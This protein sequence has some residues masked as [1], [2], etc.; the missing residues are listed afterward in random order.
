MGYPRDGILQFYISGMEKGSAYGMDLETDRRTEASL[1]EQRYFRVRYYP[2]PLAPLASLAPV[3]IRDTR[4][5]T[6]HETTRPRRM[7]FTL[8]REEISALDSSF[9]RLVGVEPYGFVESASLR[10][11]RSVESLSQ[12]LNSGAGHKIGGYPYFTQFDARAADSRLRLLLQ[13]DSDD[14]MMWGDVGVGNFFIDPEALARSDF[15]VV[16]FT[17]DN[18]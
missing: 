4:G 17:W 12:A 15:R 2:V 16:M 5:E 14:Q 7:R 18:H 6:P 9:E 11:G 1:S 10:L 13:L 3:R 8:Q